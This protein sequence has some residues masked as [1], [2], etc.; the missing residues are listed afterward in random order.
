MVTPGDK[1]KEVF[2]TENTSINGRLYGFNE[3]GE[4]GILLS[5][6]HIH[7]VP[8]AQCELKKIL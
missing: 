3:R 6:T 7:W 8:A 5:S 2:Y 1:G 4:A